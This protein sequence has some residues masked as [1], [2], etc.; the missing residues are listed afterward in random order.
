M[1]DA[2]HSLIL[3]PWHIG[4]WEDMTFQ[5]VS[6][7]NRLRCFL[8]E[9]AE[10]ARAQF[11]KLRLECADKEFLTVPVRPEAGFLD[12]V[13]ERLRQEDVGMVSSGG[14]PCFAD[15]GGWVVAGLRQRGVPV[16]ALAGASSLTTLLALSGFDWVA[17]PPSRSFSFVFFDKSG[18]QEAFRAAAGRREPVVVF[19]AAQDFAACLE[20]MREPAGARRVTAFFDL[21]KSPRSQ[22]PYADQVRTMTCAG[23]LAELSGIR[24][25]D[26]ADLALLIHPED[27]GS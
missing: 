15:P 8:A 20:A 11:L 13:G 22:Y 18:G 2:S 17:Q 27:E 10:A 26:V 25:K 23:W 21:T 6:T 4:N 12:R 14:A 16:K 5:A 9:D 1:T 3:I 24:W 19:L 7:A